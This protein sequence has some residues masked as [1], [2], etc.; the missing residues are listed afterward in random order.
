MLLCGGLLAFEN[1]NEH[2][3]PCSGIQNGAALSTS[4]DNWIKGHYCSS[5]C[6]WCRV[7]RR[8]RLRV[9]ARAWRLAEQSWWSWSA[10]TWHGTRCLTSG[11]PIP[12]LH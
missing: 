9:M 4:H 10:A 3:I 7:L 8:L 11:A 12:Q 5:T 1:L 6:P 2:G